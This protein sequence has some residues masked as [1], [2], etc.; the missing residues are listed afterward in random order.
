LDVVMLWLRCVDD[1]G[2]GGLYV[3]YIFLGMTLS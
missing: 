1:D 3:P 2:G